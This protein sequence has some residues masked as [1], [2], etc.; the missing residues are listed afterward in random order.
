MA[1][2]RKQ[3][4]EELSLKFKALPEKAANAF[5]QFVESIISPRNFNDKLITIEMIVQQPKLKDW[6]YIHSDG[7]IRLTGGKEF[8]YCGQW[9]VEYPYIDENGVFIENNITMEMPE[10]TPDCIRTLYRKTT[11]VAYLLTCVVDG[12]EYIL[13]IGMTGK[14]M[15]ER[16]SSYNC[17]NIANRY[18]GT[19]STT[20]FKIKQSLASGLTFNVYAVDC[21]ADNKTYNDG[22]RTSPEFAGPL[23]EAVEYLLNE[24]FAD[25]FGKKPL[26]NTQVGK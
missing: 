3:I 13:K 12:V 26:L 22:K 4:S 2:K 15:A 14:T 25:T 17:G 23:P 19:C 5:I 6:Q 8:K 18:N 9:N 11:G 10:G 1:K 7:F 20:N 24:D 21:S 16:E